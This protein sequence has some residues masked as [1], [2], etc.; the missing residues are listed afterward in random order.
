V[1]RGSQIPARESRARAIYPASLDAGHDLASAS[2]AKPY[3]KLYTEAAAF[4][5][6]NQRGK[7]DGKDIGTRGRQ[8]G[9]AFSLGERQR[10]DGG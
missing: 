2:A 7:R 4:R 5:D 3:L 1:F 9:D 10:R 8:A 6:S